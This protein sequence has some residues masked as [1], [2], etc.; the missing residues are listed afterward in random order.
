MILRMITLMLGMALLTYLVN[1]TSKK[2]EIT[3]TMSDTES[4]SIALFI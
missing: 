3:Q 1:D 2:R 4:I